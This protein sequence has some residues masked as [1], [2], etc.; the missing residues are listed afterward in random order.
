MNILYVR[1]IFLENKS[2]IATVLGELFQPGISTNFLCIFLIFK[3]I[4]SY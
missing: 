4:E 3:L 1:I 2:F